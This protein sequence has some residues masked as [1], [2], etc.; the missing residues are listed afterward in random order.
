T[1]LYVVGEI[2]RFTWITAAQKQLG[3]YGF[4]AMTMFG[5]I[6]YIVPCLMPSEWPSA[7][8]VKW[9]FRCAA[10]GTVLYVLPLGVGGVVEGLRLSDA[11]VAFADVLKSTLMFL[12]MSTM[13]DLLMLAGNCC[14]L[15]NLSLLCY[16]FCRSCC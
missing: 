1:S 16:R 2:T 5:A 8:L 11:N 9:H 7:K 15:V 12:R 13:G 3:L 14:V 6:Y 4:F 10:L